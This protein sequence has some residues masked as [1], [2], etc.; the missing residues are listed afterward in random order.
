[1]L[2]LILQL[3]PRMIVAQLQ[4]IHDDR[5]VTEQKYITYD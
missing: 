1:M 3:V 2:S 5:T 4:E